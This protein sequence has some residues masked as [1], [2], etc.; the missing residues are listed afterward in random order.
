M[1]IPGL[2]KLITGGKQKEKQLFAG[3]YI[4]VRMSKLLFLN[5]I[6]FL[7]TPDKAT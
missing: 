2:L 4:I 3:F 1:A 6:C 7:L 5:E